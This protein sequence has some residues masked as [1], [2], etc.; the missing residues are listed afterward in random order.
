MHKSPEDEKE[1]ENR[2]G[3]MLREKEQ[4]NEGQCR[5]KEEKDEAERKRFRRQMALY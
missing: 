5:R 4:M 2:Q 3:M 1:Q